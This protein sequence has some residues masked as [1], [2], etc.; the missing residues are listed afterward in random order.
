MTA[1]CSS[2]D[3]DSNVSTEDTINYND[4]I[5]AGAEE[6]NSNDQDIEED[7]DNQQD[8]DAEEENTAETPKVREAQE[9]EISAYEQQQAQEQAVSYSDEELEEKLAS[10]RQ[11]REEKEPI[12]LGN[13]V[14]M[15]GNVNEAEYGIFFDASILRSFDTGELMEAIDTAN[16]YVENTLGISVETRDT[17]YM[18]VDPRIWAIYS[19]EDKGVANGYEAENIYLREYRDN[20][21]WRYLILVRDGKGSAWKV[22]H[23]GSS[24]ME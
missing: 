10:Y 13:G 17:T 5:D 7:I 14:T 1:G 23:H 20:G 22:I 12:D 2:S 15:S 21:M 24:Y 16:S 3:T 9:E 8:S 18:C 19:A 11:A 4:V 6:N